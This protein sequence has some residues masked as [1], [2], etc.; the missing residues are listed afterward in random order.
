MPEIKPR[1][2]EIDP[3]WKRICAEAEEAVSAEPL[4]GGLMHSSLLHHAGFE[5]ALAYRFAMKLSSGEMSE[6]LL[7]EIADQA[8]A[9][10]PALGRAARVDLTAVHDRDPACHRYIQPILFFKG[11]QALQAYRVGHWL[12]QQ[13]RQ[14]MAY[15]VQM[16]VSESFGVDIHPAAKLGQGIMIDHAH[17]IVI[18]ETAVVGDNVS[19]LH[20]VTL[21]GTGKDDGDRHPKIGDGVLIGAGAKVLGNIHVGHCSRIAAGSVVLADVPPCSTVAGVP[22]KIVGEAGCDQPSVMMDHRLGGCDGD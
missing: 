2:A 3:V 20:S 5:D 16:R 22:A 8:Y 11:Y 7:R 19:M 18:G 17:S 14:D 10:D 4:L 12:W 15:L 9:D 6:Q 21:G 13:G 1:L